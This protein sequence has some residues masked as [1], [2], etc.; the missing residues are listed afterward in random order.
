MASK[1]EKEK[2]KEKKN[3]PYFSNPIEYYELF[4]LR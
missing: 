1:K 3:P 2:E 4:L